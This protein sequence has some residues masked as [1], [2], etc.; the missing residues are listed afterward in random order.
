[1]CLTS[2]KIKA[3]WDLTRLEHGLIY[4][5]G[6]LIALVIAARGVPDWKIALAGMLGA[7]LAEMGSFALNDY[8]DVEVD[9]KNNRMDRPIVRGDITKS[10]ALAVT[11]LTSLLSVA[12]MYFTH[13]LGA[14]LVLI[15]LVLFGAFYNARL[16]EYGIW[17]NIFIGFT[18]SAPFLFGSLLFANGSHVLFVIAAIA[19]LIGVGREVMKGIMDMEGDA[20]RNVRTVA[21]TWGPDKAN[22]LAIALYIAGIILSPVP[23]FMSDPSFHMSPIYGSFALISVVVL[24]SVCY[25]LYKGHDVKVIG[26]ARKTTLVSMSFALLGVLFA[27]LL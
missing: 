18:M 10:E 22:Y 11:V 21:R 19:F 1:M 8:Y 20:L 4:G 23:L 3:V 2:N 13:N 15:V 27:A 12:A 17:G 24:A 16:K 9:I 6:V 5:I 25:T 26:K 7:I 14:V